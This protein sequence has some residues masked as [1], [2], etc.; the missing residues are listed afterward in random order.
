MVCILGISFL[1]S[2]CLSPFPCY[3]QMSTIHLVDTHVGRKRE[4]PAPSRP[5]PKLTRALL[6]QRPDLKGA[7]GSLNR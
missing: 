5:N 6:V 3:N 7:I 4:I 1:L 2:S